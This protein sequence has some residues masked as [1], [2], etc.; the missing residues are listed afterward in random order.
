[1]QMYKNK[2]KIIKYSVIFFIALFFVFPFGATLK[3]LV[4]ART[5]EEMINDELKNLNNGIQDKQLQ[6]KDIQDQQSKYSEAIKEKQAEKA[7]LNNQLAILDN[8]VAKAQLDLELVQ[9]DIDTVKLQIQKT[10]VEI[11]N[12][13]SEIA[14]EKKHLEDVLRLIYKGDNVSSLEIILLNSSLA[15]F[16]SQVKYL[17]DVNANIEESLKGLEKLKDQLEKENQN[18]VKQNEDLALLKKELEIKK[19]KIEEE[20]N[21]KIVVLDQVG[22]SESEF[23]RLLQ[24]AKREQ[25]N[26]A[27]EIASM[28][29]KIRAKLEALKARKLESNPN[30]LIWPVTKTLITAYFHD[31]DYP[32]KNIFEHPAIDI[33]AR[34]GTTLRAAASG[35]VARV[36]FDGSSNYA[37]IMIVHGD[38]LSTVY[39]HVS[40]TSVKEDDYVT[41]GQV[42]GQSGGMPGSPGSGK[43]TTGSHLHFEV[44]L[45]GI[46]VD[47]LGYLQ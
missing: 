21:T 22:A 13:E 12:Q 36:K 23:Q 24:Q 47:P 3:S 32:F 9:T 17:E 14:K 35:Y 18:L 15:D 19:T 37:Y 38:G 33:R 2:I 1:M 45:N 41:Q 20:K 43:L 34:Q 42:I 6:V 5:E 25:E 11:K 29:K 40:G 46:P 27:A 39:G 7:S 10:D 16:L 28:E 4:L 31:P 30:G 8:R 44:R 26:A